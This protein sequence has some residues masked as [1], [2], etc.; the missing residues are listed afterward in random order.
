MVTFNLYTDPG[1]GWL[2]V[3]KHLL[4]E[5]RIQWDISS[6]SYMRGHLAYLEEDCDAGAFVVAYRKKYER[7]PSIEEHYKE[8][9]PIRDYERY[10]AGSSEGGDE[11]AHIRAAQA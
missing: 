11:T 2:E 9:T 4:V 8:V 6:Y 1:H 5:L 7:G 3:P 10:Q